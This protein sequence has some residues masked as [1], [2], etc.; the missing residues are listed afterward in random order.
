MKKILCLY[1]EGNSFMLK[2]YE[3]KQNIEKIIKINSFNLS[4]YQD[5]YYFQQKLLEIIPEI[6]AEEVYSAI[7]VLLSKGINYDGKEFVNDLTKELYSIYLVR[8]NVITRR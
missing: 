7:E 2:S 4:E 3:L 5:K 6:S 1:Q 8:N